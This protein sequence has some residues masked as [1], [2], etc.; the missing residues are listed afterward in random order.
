MGMLIESFKILVIVVV[1]WSAVHI[2]VYHLP[3]K[4]RR[5]L[6]NTFLMA[7]F[8][9]T[10]VVLVV[11]VA[12]LEP[13]PESSRYYSDNAFGIRHGDGYYY[14]LT[15]VSVS[16]E[17]RKRLFGLGENRPINW[18]KNGYHYLLSFVYFLFGPSILIGKFVN[19]V[20]GAWTSI[21]AYFPARWIKD[22]KAGRISVLLCAVNP[23]MI[24][25]S[26]TLLKESLLMFLLMLLVISTLKFR[27]QVSAMSLIAVT[28]L[29]TYI[30]W[31]RLAYGFVVVV[32]LM[33]YAFLE[34]FYCNR[35]IRI[36][37]DRSVYI[38]G[39]VLTRALQ[40]AFFLVIIV[41]GINIISHKTGLMGNRAVSMTALTSK[42]SDCKRTIVSRSQI[43]GASYIKRHK[44]LDANNNFSPKNLIFSAAKVIW[45]PTL[46]YSI[47][48]HGHREQ[49]ALY[50]FPMSILVMLIGPFVFEGIFEIVKTKNASG[51]LICLLVGAIVASSVISLLNI[52]PAMLRKRAPAMPFL[53]ILGGVGLAGRETKAKKR[54][55]LAY[56]TLGGCVWLVY[57]VYYCL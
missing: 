52:H 22:T 14:N 17:L 1:A 20:L 32:V 9:R 4:E 21:L 16:S 11:F 48:A 28:L 41:F 44:F 5:F 7:L 15:A 12:N 40:Y 27:R 51:L 50:Y 2:C 6:R 34:L 3:N 55:R 13:L 57:T 35:W 42:L 29:L 24:Y 39:H 8:L 10:V 46:P 26:S 47:K 54:L 36:P 33:C 18:N 25:W 37:K 19:A 45:T 56:Y 30:T 53:M 38:S 49:A 43:E 23:G 31:V